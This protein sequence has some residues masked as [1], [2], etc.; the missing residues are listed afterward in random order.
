M[1]YPHRSDDSVTGVRAEGASR[2]R[3]GRDVM[4]HGYVPSQKA[5]F[6]DL[7]FR[8]GVR[9]MSHERDPGIGGLEF[10]QFLR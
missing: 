9:A 6:V 5:L 4:E 8:E 3:S 1:T 7:A 2:P 10:P